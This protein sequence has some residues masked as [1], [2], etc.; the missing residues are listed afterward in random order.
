MTKRLGRPPSWTSEQITAISA[1]N[2]DIQALSI[3]LGKSIKAIHT[4][5]ER[6]HLTPTRQTFHNLTSITGHLTDAERGYISGMLDGEGSIQFLR[7]RQ[8]RYR[9]LVTIS[10]NHR[11]VINWLKE[12]I[13]EGSISYR[14]H[15][16]SLSDSTIY[17]WKLT[18]TPAMQFLKEIT[19]YLIVKHK[20]A[21][22]LSTGYTHL[23]LPER[24]HLFH[25][26]KGQT[27]NLSTAPTLTPNP[28]L[29]LIRQR[30]DLNSSVI[31]HLTK[32]EKG[33][34]AGLLDGDGS[35]RFHVNR[36]IIPKIKTAPNYSLQVTFYNIHF[37]VIAWLKSKIPIGRIYTVQ[38]SS[39]I[40]K[41]PYHQFRLTTN[42]SIVIL[43]E[44][45]PYLIIKYA[46]AKAF[47]QG[48]QC[49]LFPERD[50]LLKQ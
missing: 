33:Y 41:Y 3:A 27:I 8:T 37:G 31:G 47:S 1:P 49:L 14:N 42:P 29:P 28:P 7:E 30:F 6:L 10:N 43:R 50:K 4:K 35:I 48:Y 46:R 32:A 22:I 2:V 26:L 18:T 17:E 11:G 44:L 15:V 24:N 25:Q 13:P 45:L 36:I 20:R 16:G 12:K 40:S 9:I 39:R 5:R 21:A 34:I 23:S 38:Q 19:P